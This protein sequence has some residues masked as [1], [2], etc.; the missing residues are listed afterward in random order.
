MQ[1]DSYYLENFKFVELSECQ[2]TI[3]SDPTVSVSYSHRFNRQL[4]IPSHFFKV[5]RNKFFHQVDIIEEYHNWNPKA[6]HNPK[7]ISKS[8]FKEVLQFKEDNPGYREYL[9]LD[10]IGCFYSGISECNYITKVVICV[11]ISNNTVFNFSI[12]EMANQRDIMAELIFDDLNYL[13]KHADNLFMEQVYA[14]FML[15]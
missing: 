9:T 11:D 14:K 8:T 15:S 4:T 5:N 12:R 7:Y 13:T 6:L 2:Y 10:F 3:E 1:L